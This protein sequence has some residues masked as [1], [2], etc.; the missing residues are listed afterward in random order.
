MAEKIFD[1]L[2]IGNEKILVQ[3]CEL[4]QS[5]LKFYPEN[6]RV[7]SALNADGSVPSQ[8]IIEEHMK[9]LDHVRELRDDIQMNGG[10]MEAIIVRDGDFVVLEGNSRLAAYRLLCEKDPVKWGKIKARL[11]PKDIDESLVFKLL[12]Q[13]HIKGRKDWEPYEQANY[14]YRRTIESKQPIEYIAKELGIDKKKAKDYVE[15]IK[16]MIDKKDHVT[17]N[18]S[19][20]YE[21]I[22]DPTLRKYRDTTP[23]IDETITK[24]IKTHT[25]ER[26]EDIRLLKDVAK[27]NDKQS[28]KLMQKFISGDVSLYDAHDA[29][30]ENGKLDDCVAKLR[31]FKNYIDDESFEKKVKSSP[32]VYEKAIYEIGKI[33]SRLK[34][35]EKKWN[36]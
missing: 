33:S 19:Y 2:T 18:F 34:N 4:N 29:V 13:F 28:K 16:F 26:A 20:Y 3:L 21:Y 35:L 32:E 22:K 6:P 10:L 14:L 8:E 12:G 1:Q 31:K 27:V 24:Q 36:K 23:E 15:A 5:D 9:S 7:Y 11:L 17:R 25:I 30:E